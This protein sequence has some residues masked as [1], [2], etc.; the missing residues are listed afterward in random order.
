MFTFKLFFISIFTFSLLSPS[1]AWSLFKEKTIIER[2]VSYL[3]QWF[4]STIELLYGV[5][6]SFIIHLSLEASILLVFITVVI[7]IGYW[8]K[9]GRHG[10]SSTCRTSANI[11]VYN[12]MQLGNRKNEETMYSE[13]RM[14]LLNSNIVK[15]PEVFTDGMDG[16]SWITVVESFL[17]DFPKIEWVRITISYIDNKI[18]KQIENLEDCLNDAITGFQKFKIQFLKATNADKH[19]NLQQVSWDSLS[20]C[21]Q[22]KNQTIQE[23]GDL[24]NSIAK[25]LFP[26]ISGTD[27]LDRLMQ[28]RFVDGLLNTRLKEIART[29][30]FKM[31]LMKK[32]EPF[33]FHDLVNYTNCK[34]EGFEKYGHVNFNNDSMVST[35]DSD[36]G[37]NVAKQKRNLPQLEYHP[38]HFEQNQMVPSHSNNSNPKPYFNKNNQQQNQKPWMKTQTNTYIQNKQPNN[39][40]T[41]ENYEFWTQ[42]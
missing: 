10:T 26:N 32:N 14:C 36:F 40:D 35:S 19:T 7:S 16:K 31:K 18:L 8:F 34:N 15:C 37:N 17:K 24:I 2:I 42:V 11:N 20:G 33:S 41:K 1:Y 25:S 12:S 5:S 39:S 9:K 30:M 3:I 28:E 21:K 23:Y 22:T 38:N 27:D 4:I 13:S 6:K 29:K